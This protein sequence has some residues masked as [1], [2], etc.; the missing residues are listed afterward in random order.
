MDAFSDS[1]VER[2]TVQK[3]PQSG[4]TEAVY[5]MIGYSICEDPG[6]A[7]LVDPRDVDSEYVVANRLRP[8]V[9]ASEQLQGHTTGRAWDLSNQ[10]FHFDRMTLYFVASNSPAGLGSKP[11]RFLF[12]DE[13]NKYPPFVGREASTIDL[14]EKR[15]ITFWDRKIVEIST[16]TTANGN[17]SVSFRRSNMQEYY[18][19]CPRCGE[20]AVLKFDQLKLPKELREPDRIRRQPG[21]V[22]YECEHCGGR[23]EEDEK[24]AMVAGGRWLA[25]GQQIDAAGNITGEPLR[26]KRHSGFHFSALISPWV[27]WTEIMAQWFAANTEEGVVLGK[28]LDFKNAILGEPY[29]ESG[30]RIESKKLRPLRGGYSQGTVPEDCILLVAAA[31]Y[32]KSRLKKIVRIEYEVRGFGYGLK[33]YVITSGQLPSFEALSERVLLSPFPWAD[34]T[35]PEQRP[36]LA[37]PVLF[38]D[39]GYEPNDVYDYCR[40]RP[41]VTIPTKGEPGPRATPLQARP[42][43]KATQQRLTAQQRRRYRGMQLLLV[44][45]Y[46]FKDQ[47]TSWVEPRTDEDEET[48]VTKI[49]A[50]P[51]TSFYDEIPDY[52]FKE[53]CNEHKVQ[54]RD[55]RGNL[56]WEWR[57]ASTGA[58]T[59]ALDTAVL[60]A[61]AGFYKRV[62]YLR[63]PR[64]AVPPP[65]AA[66]RHRPQQPRRPRKRGGFLD[67]LPSV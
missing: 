27:S 7:M 51:L 34:G 52:Y 65:A 6:P 64:A 43:E 49:I 35:P 63:D 26:D 1:E 66:Q 8:M 11:I 18:C 2:I 50:P 9:E 61:A 33:N 36:W 5:N 54:V 44:D 20:Y 22:W 42:L 23:I 41:G 67:N 57:P 59:H 31:D 29:E 32:H 46:Y 39:S 47:V 58:S 62:H 38:V 10:E 16:P 12:L 53:F 24:E 28:L 17:I 56:K 40:Q 30:R 15:T 48:G 4:V 3:V 45:T 25:A 13:T 60:C 14:A 21:C 19:P 55:R 37:V